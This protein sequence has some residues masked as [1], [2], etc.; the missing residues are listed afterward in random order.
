M[1]RIKVPMKLIDNSKQIQLPSVTCYEILVMRSSVP[2]LVMLKAFKKDGPKAKACWDVKTEY[3]C[4]T[5][6]PNAAE[7]GTR[8]LSKAVITD[9]LPLRMNESWSEVIDT[10]A[11]KLP[12]VVAVRFSN[13][14]IRLSYSDGAAAIENKFA[15][16]SSILISKEK[17]LS[18]FESKVAD[19][20]YF[21]MHEPGG[22][23]EGG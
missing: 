1:Y 13:P 21:Q 11:S 2:I 19:L 3:S 7:E 15:P 16:L 4:I 17:E 20:S 6:D 23:E 5:L 12:K 22:A 9:E 18:P 10:K 8:T 14:S